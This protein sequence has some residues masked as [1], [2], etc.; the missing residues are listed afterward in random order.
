MRLHSTA[1]IIRLAAEEVFGFL[2]EDVAADVGDGVGEGDLLGAGL[3]AVL[4]EAALLDSAIACEGAETLFLEDFAGWVIVEEL[5]L[6]DGGGA[7][8]SR[9][10]VKLRADFHAAG[11]GDAI[12]ERVIHFL[13]L[14]EDARAGTQVVRAVDGDPGFDAH[15]IFKEDGA[16]DLEIANERELGEGLD[17][18]GLFEIVDEGRAGHTGLSVDAHGTG[19]ADFLKTIGVVGNGRG[20]LAVGGDG[21]GS[22]LHHGGDDVHAGTPFEFEV[23]PCGRSVG[24]GLTLDFEFNGLCHG[25]AFPQ[26]GR[27]S[28]ASDVVPVQNIVPTGLDEY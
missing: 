26:F 12:G 24:G 21:V 22:D 7:D 25:L 13:L 28:R 2:D 14:G 20:G 15:E 4:S 5:D 19:A 1:L 17:L 18:D 27:S 6:G 16:V 23:F 3:D 10:L 11:A 8:E 9:F